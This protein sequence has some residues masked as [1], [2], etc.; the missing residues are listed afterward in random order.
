[1]KALILAGGFGTRLR[2]LSCTRPKLVFPIANR[3]LL[4]VTLQKLAESGVE[5]VALAVNFMADI[6]E[7]TFGKSKYGMGIHYSKD[8]PLEETETAASPQKSLGTGGALKRAESLL[9]VKEPFFV[10]NGD[11]LTDTNYLKLFEEHKRKDGLATLALYRVNDPT[12][13]GIARLAR[14]SRVIEFVEK[15]LGQ[16]PSNLANAGI[17]VLEPDVFDYIKAGKRC[18]IEREVFPKLAR[19]RKLFGHE[20]SGL[21]IDIGKPSDL[22]K[23]NR[24]WLEFGSERASKC[25]DATIGKTTKI[26]EAV[27]LGEG[28]VVG[29]KSEIGPNVS[30]GKSADVGNRVSIRDSIIFPNTSISDHTRIVGAII[31]DSVAIG[32]GVIVEEGCLVGD[33]SIIQDNVKLAQN[34]KICPSK[35]ISHDIPASVCVM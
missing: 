17:Y 35:T 5:E 34:V 4:D 3:P 20:I 29:E 18:S 2:P 33:S 25:K 23:A 7:Q 9:G 31:G 8:V 28:V 22:I 24:L 21:W 13:Y 1:L 27:A 10:L 19:E 15:P 26:K 11:I 16:G 14:N 6:L 12:R 30:L 32:K